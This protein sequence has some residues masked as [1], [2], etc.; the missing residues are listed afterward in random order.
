MKGT[1]VSGT[2]AGLIALALTSAFVLLPRPV[3][4]L[5]SGAGYGDEHHLTEKVSSAFVG[6]WRS[7]RQPLTP[8]LM[9]LVD[10]WRWYH[11]VK[12]ITAMG[13]L[14]LLLLLAARLRTRFTPTDVTHAMRRPSLGGGVAAAV[15]ALFAFVLALANVQGAIAPFSSLLSLLPVTTARGDLATTIEEVR[16][17][18]A[19]Y[20]RGSSAALRM[21][22]GDLTVYHVVVAVISSLTAVALVG[23]A[24]AW[25]RSDAR[26]GSGDRES[27]RLRRTFT[28]GAAI[29]AASFAVLG[30]A[31]TTTAVNSPSAVLDFYRGG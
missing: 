9:Q 18:A 26:T 24:V 23:L 11:L 10:Y 5:L 1:R 14:V 31:N 15:L 20:P 2:V 29:V 3:A 30:F 25:K 4:T 27:R 7:A 6:Y 21:I 19:N 8:E 12:A 17:Q 28:V 22:V 13:L 16:Q